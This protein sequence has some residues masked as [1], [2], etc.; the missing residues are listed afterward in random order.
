MYV[1]NWSRYNLL[2]KS[3]NSFIYIGGILRNF[4][5]ESLVKEYK[6]L[7]GLNQCWKP[8]IKYKDYQTDK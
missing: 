1:R 4:R 6:I 3:T 2:L 7:I 8:E 5:K